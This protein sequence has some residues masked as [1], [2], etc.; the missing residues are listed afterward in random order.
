MRDRLPAKRVSHARC[1]LPGCL[2]IGSGLS[3]AEMEQASSLFSSERHFQP[4]FRLQMG[5]SS[6]HVPLTSFNDSFDLRQRINFDDSFGE[7]SRNLDMLRPDALQY[8]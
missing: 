4:T 5:K 3:P 1:S 2:P 6:T 7:A 8:G